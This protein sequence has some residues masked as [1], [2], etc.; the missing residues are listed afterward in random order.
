[1]SISARDTAPRTRE[2]TRARILHAAMDLFGRDGFDETTVKAVARRCGVTD[3]ALY[4]HFRSKKEILDALLETSDA[5]IANP[6]A[7]A[8]ELDAGVLARLVD[9]L[10]DAAADQD[11]LLRLI[12]RQVLAGDRTAI[13]LRNQAMAAWRR[14]LL[15]HFET[16]Y[17]RDAAR[18]QAEVLL[19]LVFGL[20]SLAQID[21]GPRFPEVARGAAFREYVQGLVR[22]ALPLRPAA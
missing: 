1:M 22:L 14:Q 21:H 12:V 11:A 6:P 17:D 9:G 5:L 2:E 19:M 16:R 4:Y 7:P 8:G 10:I 3:A 18:V 20:T 13:A 15:P